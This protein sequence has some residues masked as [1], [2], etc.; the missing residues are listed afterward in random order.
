MYPETHLGF[1]SY[2][3]S[4]KDRIVT[5]TGK[6]EISLTTLIPRFSTIPSD[7]DSNSHN[8]TLYTLRNINVKLKFA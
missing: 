7:R 2:V 5:E 1:V 8:N 3:T 4:E 6:L